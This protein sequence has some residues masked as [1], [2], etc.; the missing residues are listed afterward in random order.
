MKAKRWLWGTAIALLV[1]CGLLVL[2]AL[3]ATNSRVRSEACEKNLKSLFV[4]LRLYST[5]HNGRLPN[6]LNELQKSNYYTCA[7]NG[8][9]YCPG[10][11]E[12][13]WDYVYLGQQSV[14]LGDSV[15]VCWDIEPHTIR[16]LFGLSVL[17]R[18]VLFADGT[19]KRVSEPEFRK[20]IEKISH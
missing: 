1:A 5:L 17:F 12:H 13:S 20:S 15:P 9:P 4:Q 7:T 18:N 3:V 10:T 6:S 11:R 8:V 19:V 2:D 14:R 16:H